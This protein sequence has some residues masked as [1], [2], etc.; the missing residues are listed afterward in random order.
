MVETA[1]KS[2]AEP[3]QYALTGNDGRSYGG[4][5]MFS[6]YLLLHPALKP[7]EKHILQYMIYQAE[8]YADLQACKPVLCKADQQQI[9]HET[10]NSRAT[11]Q[12]ALKRAE[13]FGL[14]RRVGTH[15]QAL[16]ELQP[17][18]WPL[19]GDA[20]E[21]GRRWQDW[22]LRVAD[23]V[24]SWVDRFFGQAVTVEAVEEFAREESNVSS[25][26]PQPKK[27]R[28]HAHHS[29]AEP[30]NE[31]HED[32][33]HCDAYGNSIPSDEQGIPA[34]RKNR[35]Q[36][37]DF[38]AQPRARAGARGDSYS[39][40]IVGTPRA[41]PAGSLSL[42]GADSQQ[43]QPPRAA[44]GEIQPD[45]SAGSVSPASPGAYTV[46][47]P[48][49]E[50]LRQDVAAASRPREKKVHWRSEFKHTYRSRLRD[51]YDVEFS[52]WTPKMERQIS[53]IHRDFDGDFL[54]RA[55]NWLFD[56]WRLLKRTETGLYDSDAYPPFRV[57]VSYSM[58]KKY[59]PYITGKETLKPA[60]R[61]GVGDMDDKRNWFAHTQKQLEDPN[62]FQM[63][64]EDALAFFEK[65]LEERET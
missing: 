52:R 49:S 36:D 24:G 46:Y 40:S 9:I 42:A 62:A 51:E 22:A 26:V 60:R 37:G 65:A 16:Y 14:V 1:R 31:A 39:I 30:Q 35:V 33:H 10:R 47:T 5:V 56:N 27:K 23:V 44:P 55:A 63:S 34:P 15:K 8:S 4:F 45:G 7:V 53:Q 41:R 61:K 2:L 19:L 59:E 29:D 21:K 18:P 3:N 64:E 50:K 12:R 13:G 17:G 6:T 48:K 54:V 11:T 28:S 32:G 57:L 58:V 38:A 20:P 43:A 25:F